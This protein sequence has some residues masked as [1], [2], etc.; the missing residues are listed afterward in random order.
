MLAKQQASSI[1]A[2]CENITLSEWEPSFI[3]TL[4]EL[5]K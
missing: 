4:T 3:D 2:A 1:L 5:T